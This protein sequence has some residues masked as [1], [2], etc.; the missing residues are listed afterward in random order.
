MNDQTP[1]SYRNQPDERGH[2]GDF[3]GRYV[4]ETLMPLILALENAPENE[5]A[6]I[7]RIVRKRK[8]SPAAIREVVRWVHDAGGVAAARARM[9]ELAADAA[10]GFRQFPAGEAREALIGLCAYVVARKK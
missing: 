2:F 4:A 10:D 5:A 9:E 7:R 3:G 6:R 1:N 8:K